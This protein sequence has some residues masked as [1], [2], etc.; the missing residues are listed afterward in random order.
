MAFA[1]KRWSRERVISRVAYRNKLDLDRPISH[2]LLYD[3]VAKRLVDGDAERSFLEAVA[4]EWLREFKDVRGEVWYDS[5]QVLAAFPESGGSGPPPEL[6]AMHPRGR[7]SDRNPNAR[8]DTAELREEMGRASTP[9]ELGPSEQVRAV[10]PETRG[11]RPPPRSA[12]VK[13]KTS[14]PLFLAIA[15]ELKALHPDGRPVGQV[16]DFLREIEELKKFRRF[17]KRTF[18]RAMQRAWGPGPE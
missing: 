12:P 9:A 6:R 13:T 18:E 8:H 14:K 1:C 17:S 2:G 4:K 7:A 15:E 16:E 5:E 11:S 10:V 3:D